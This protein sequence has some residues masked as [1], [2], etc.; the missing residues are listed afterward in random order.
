[1]GPP[2]ELAVRIGIPDTPVKRA[3]RWWIPAA[4]ALFGL[5]APADAA[6][7]SNA[8]SA[9]AFFEKQ[10]RPLLADAF[11]IGNAEGPLTTRR[12]PYFPKQKWSYNALPD[13]ARARRDGRHCAPGRPH[14]H[15]RGH[16]RSGDP[17]SLSRGHRPPGLREVAQSVEGED[18]LAGG[19]RSVTCRLGGGRARSPHDR[20]RQ[21]PDQPRLDG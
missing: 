1:M 14:V 8:D 12:E 3:V 20:A 2:G 16:G 18:V 10:V 6:T 9:L 13:G 11:V 21:L 19:G 17:R 15:R 5:T 7:K 4:L